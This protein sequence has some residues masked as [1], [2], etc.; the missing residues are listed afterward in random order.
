M[1]KPA[2]LGGSRTIDTPFPTQITVGREEA[3]AVRQV[4]ETG[5]LSHFIAGNRPEFYG[6]PKV[7]E[8]EARW[9]ERFACGHA[10]AVNSAT[11]GLIAAVGAVGI[12]PGD[13]VI[14]S[15]WTMSATPAAVL[16]FNGIPVFCGH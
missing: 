16:A 15:P 11:S 3:D 13:E 7:R 5:L 1:D 6:G 12:G 10:V 2:L 8:L 14:T 9:A 4:M